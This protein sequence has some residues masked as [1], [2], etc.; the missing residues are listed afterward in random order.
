MTK[1]QLE[2]GQNLL[3]NLEAHG[4]LLE[5]VKC[6][7]AIVI[8]STGTVAAQS[9]EIFSTG[10]PANSYLNS[11]L[12]LGLEGDFL[13]NPEIR[14]LCRNFHGKLISLIEEEV[15]SLQLKFEKL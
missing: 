11:G 3:A 8:G 12:L 15:A 1:S 9:T 4:K 5:M 13:G 14:E 6:S 2:K 7:G 10:R